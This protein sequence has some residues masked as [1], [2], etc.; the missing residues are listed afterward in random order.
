MVKLIRK[1]CKMS[2]KFEDYGFTPD[3]INLPEMVSE[4]KILSS[5]VYDSRCSH[6]NNIIA[7]GEHHIPC[8]GLS[9]SSKGGSYKYEQC[10]SMRG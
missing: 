5:V 1:D 7:P 4:T 3:W 9:V 2:I 6:C 10:L 8:G